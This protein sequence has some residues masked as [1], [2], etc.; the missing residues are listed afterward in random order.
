MITPSKPPFPLDHKVLIYDTTIF[1]TILV[2]R[3][4]DL[5]GFLIWNHL[6]LGVIIVGTSP[7]P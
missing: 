4:F 3:D 6:L 5:P 7:C 2:L 1:L